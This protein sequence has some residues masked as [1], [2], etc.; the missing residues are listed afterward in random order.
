LAARGPGGLRRAC[1]EVMSAGNIV[2]AALRKR[3]SEDALREVSERLGIELHWNISPLGP[4]V[5]GEVRDH[6]VTVS[7]VGGKRNQHGLRTRYRVQLDETNA[8]NFSATK[9][10]HDD[11]STVLTGDRRFDKAVK[12]V[13]DK[14]ADL[15][16]YLTAAR[17]AAILRLLLQWPLAEISTG[18]ATVITD[19]IEADSRRLIESVSHLVATAESFDEQAENV[20]SNHIRRKEKV[21]LDQ[22]SVLKSLFGPETNTS[23]TAAR[24]AAAYQGQEIRW[25]GTVVRIG[26]VDR[27]SQKIAVSVDQQHE[28]GRVTALTSVSPNMILGEGDPVTFRGEL[29][30]LD[31]PKRLFRVGRAG[32]DLSQPVHAGPTTSDALL[33]PSWLVASPKVWTRSSRP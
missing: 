6:E 25:T 30:S 4:I 8:P 9:R 11:Y 28:H 7:L 24:F 22:G 21:V 2:L 1:G 19:G 17:R 33:A 10:L 29:L 3:R 18:Q 12:I 27:T 23:E 20:P 13:T 14:P 26:S 31:A 16:E 5:R 32:A 15:R